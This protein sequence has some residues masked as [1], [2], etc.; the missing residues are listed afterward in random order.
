MLHM[1]PDIYL[2]M[3]PVPEQMQ[4]ITALSNADLKWETTN[5]FNMGV[6]FSALNGRIFGNVDYYVSQ[7][8]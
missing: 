7:T 1:M 2:E 3:V 5:T 8:N 6:D 4:W